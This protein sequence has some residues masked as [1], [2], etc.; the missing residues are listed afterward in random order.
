MD[1]DHEQEAQ[2]LS[3]ELS[4]L[5]NQLSKLQRLHLETQLRKQRQL[6]DD[7][8]CALWKLMALTKAI[9][10]EFNPVKAPP[11]LP[12]IVQE[13]P[14]TWEES[15]KS[16][17]DCLEEANSFSVEIAQLYD[18][19]ISAW[20]R[21]ADTLNSSLKVRLDGTRG[22]LESERANL[23][24]LQ[25]QSASCERVFG[26]VRRKLEEQRHKYDEADKY[27]WYW[28]P[29]RLYLEILK[30]IIEALTNDV[31]SAERAYRTAVLAYEQAHER[32]VKADKK[33]EELDQLVQRQVRL[34]CQGESLL[35]QSRS[36]MQSAE[37][38]QQENVKLKNQRYEAW[39]LASACLNRAELVEYNLFKADYA[40][41]ILLV[42]EQGLK[43]ITLCSQIKPIVYHLRDF[44]DSKHSVA[45]IT[46]DEH[47]QGLLKD[48]LAQLPEPV[49]FMEAAPS[50]TGQAEINHFFLLRTAASNL[51]ASNV[52]P[53]NFMV[54][55]NSNGSETLL[56][57]DG[58]Q[59][60][61]PDESTIV[62][63]LLL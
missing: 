44:D 21:R 55:M 63:L 45:S 49:Q 3:E 58:T 28:P 11:S 40:K 23:R 61:L 2:R 6:A 56:A 9:D 36:L 16:S 19:G 26:D 37:K 7:T 24:Q 51:A 34:V 62:S 17:D 20:K 46:T 1:G 60:S 18:T 32:V 43:D 15:K 4:S 35:F 48:I 52:A 50:I 29:A 57:E 53:D 5:D 14:R 12:S 10:G 8:L 38:M 25:Q 39:Q 27:T 13:L 33:T 42:A 59:P 31:A 54:A 22:A 30:P 47:P 41:T